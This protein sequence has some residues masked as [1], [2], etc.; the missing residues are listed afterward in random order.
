MLRG[1]TSVEGSFST[2][3]V[4]PGFTGQYY[5]RLFISSK[6]K[7]KVCAVVPP[8]K[9]SVYSTEWAPYEKQTLRVVEVFGKWVPA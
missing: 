6:Y 5:R 3:L 4:F 7:H 9:A 2:N 1:V 8:L